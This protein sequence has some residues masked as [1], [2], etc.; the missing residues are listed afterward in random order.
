MGRLSS[1]EK[2][3]DLDINTYLCLDSSIS[4]AS[5]PSLFIAGS[6][7]EKTYAKAKA[8][9]DNAGN[10]FAALAS[11]PVGR[12][13]TYSEAYG[14][15]YAMIALQ[16]LEWQLKGKEWSRKIFTGEECICM[17]SGWEIEYRN[18][19]NVIH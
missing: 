8:D 18:E 7:D 10:S 17:Y 16:W 14:G 12:E 2:L 1:P 3:S 9:L 5:K 11:I 4:D 19:H 13:G 6:L 15:S